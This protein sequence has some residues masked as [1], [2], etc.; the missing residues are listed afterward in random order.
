MKAQQAKENEEQSKRLLRIQQV[1]E[2]ESRRLAEEQRQ[3]AA[4]RIKAEQDRV[5][6]E[7]IEKQLKE[8]KQGVKI[9]LE[10]PEDISELDSGRIRAMKLA[11]LEK[12]KN[13]LSEQLRIAGKRIDHLE[14][15]YRQEEVKHLKDD[16]EKQMERDAAAYE[17]SKNEELKAA[18]QK[19]KDD[20]ALKHRLSRL[21]PSY[22]KFTSEVKQARRAEFEKRSK[23]AQKDLEQKKAKR[24]AE[25]KEKMAREKREREEAERRQREEEEREREEAEAKERADE[26]R[27][28]KMQAE[29]EDREA[30]RRYVYFPRVSSMHA[31]LIQG[32]GREGCSSTPTRRRGRSQA[33]GS[34]E[35]W[36]RRRPFR[37]SRTCRCLSRRS[38]PPCTGWRQTLVA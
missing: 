15:A 11:A 7:E 25:L 16:Y 8:L 2:E 17:K 6:R 32:V 23:I 31:N 13:Q 10:I 9:D 14:R 21:V 38:S 20:V 36:I 30:R 19:H 22:Q 28:A 37:A 4:Q 24:V 34:K 26:E 12:E 27:R 5:Q 33:R 35:I 1:K 18:E 3:R 29:K